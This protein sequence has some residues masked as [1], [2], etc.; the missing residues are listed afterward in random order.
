MSTFVA[1]GL[2]IGL[3][4]LRFGI[5]L[6]ALDL[7]NRR[8]WQL[9]LSFGLFEA[10]MPLAGVLVGSTLIGA[11]EFDLDW[12]GP[13]LL[14]ACGLMVLWGAIRR[15]DARNRL[16]G[17]SWLFAF[18]LILSID[19]LLAGGALA[20]MDVPLV[21]AVCSVGLLSAA[22]SLV[23]LY[24]GS[25]LVRYIPARSDLVAAAV[26]LVASVVSLVPIV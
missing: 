14:A 13:A 26:I 4:N 11:F 17:S 24:C 5:G 19:N 9:A 25:A 12:L 7:G 20:A 15:A 16:A 22:L 8:R 1:L 10:F 21:P 23:G 6:G 18:P 3:D 2:L